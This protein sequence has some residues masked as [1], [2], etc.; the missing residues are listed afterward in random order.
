MV[1]RLDEKV[2]RGNR[3]SILQ[4][5]GFIVSFVDF[6]TNWSEN[7]VRDA[8]EGALSGAIDK[9]CP[10]PRLVRVKTKWAFSFYM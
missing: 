10:H 4:Q 5:E 2:P 9:Q 7:K 6:W 8:V 3:R 1:D